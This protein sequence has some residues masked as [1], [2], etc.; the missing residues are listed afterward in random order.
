MYDYFQECLN[1]LNPVSVWLIDY[2]N[3]SNFLEVCVYRRVHLGNFD[4]RY[5]G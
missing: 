1:Q 3:K 5:T 2:S 4:E